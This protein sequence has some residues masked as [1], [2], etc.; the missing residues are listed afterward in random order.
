MLGLPEL[1]PFFTPADLSCTLDRRSPMTQIALVA[2][3]MVSLAPAA[4]AQAAASAT[5]PGSA[6]VLSTLVSRGFFGIEL[7]EARGRRFLVEANG[8]RGA[9]LR[10][11]V[12]GLT[13]WISNVDPAGPLGA[14]GNPVR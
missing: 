8:P 14:G 5:G 7:I 11:T 6:A 2:T 9:R 4:F 13:G 10:F 12:D 3:L 1:H